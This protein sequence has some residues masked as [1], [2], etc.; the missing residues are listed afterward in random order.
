MNNQQL[1]KILEKIQNLSGVDHIVAMH[2]LLKILLENYLQKMKLGSDFYQYCEKHNFNVE[3]I[4]RKKEIDDDYLEFILRQFSI[5][6]NVNHSN[7]NNIG[8]FRI[9]FPFTPLELVYWKCLSELELLDICKIAETYLEKLD[10]IKLPPCYKKNSDVL[11]S[12]RLEM[13]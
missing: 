10:M 9:E 2:V 11:E 3:E 12:G 8:E 4:I 7:N 5:N 6:I 13:G 1:D